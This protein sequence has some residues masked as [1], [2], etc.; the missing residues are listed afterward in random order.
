M[1]AAAHCM[2][3]LARDRPRGRTLR[4]AVV[5]VVMLWLKR[6]RNRVGRPSVVWRTVQAIVHIGEILAG[7]F[8]LS[9]DA[10][11]S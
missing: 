6:V 11:R 8:V 9:S 1:L 3:L 7:S 5:G 4:G 2:R 10:L